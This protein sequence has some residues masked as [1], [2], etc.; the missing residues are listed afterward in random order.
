M[1]KRFTKF[2]ALSV[3]LMTPAASFA[4]EVSQERCKGKNSERYAAMVE[5][6]KI[7]MEKQK[8]IFTELLTSGSL[9]EKEHNAIS[10]YLQAMEKRSQKVKKERKGCGKKSYKQAH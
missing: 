2:L 7:V 5:G 6:R 4:E 9:T 8:E 1:I 3:I 10:K